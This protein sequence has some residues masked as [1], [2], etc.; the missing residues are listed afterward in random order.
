MTNSQWIE[1][2]HMIWLLADLMHLLLHLL[3]VHIAAWAPWQHHAPLVGISFLL[4]LIVVHIIV[5]LH[6]VLFFELLLISCI[7]IYFFMGWRALAI[8]RSLTFFHTSLLLLELL[9][10]L[11]FGCSASHIRVRFLV[12]VLGCCCVWVDLT[13][14]LSLLFAQ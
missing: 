1:L 4:L 13:R 9:E 8:A 5:L 7:L 3:W 6:L 10:C 11:D 2:W 14:H 12:V